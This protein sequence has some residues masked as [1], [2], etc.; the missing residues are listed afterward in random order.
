[1]VSV[2]DS[3]IKFC[4]LNLMP[5]VR[6]VHPWSPI[7]SLQLPLWLSRSVITPGFSL[8]I[9][10]ISVLLIEAGTYCLAP[11]LTRRSAIRQNSIS[12]CA[13]M[14]AFR[15][16]AGLLIIMFCGTRTNLLLMSCKLSQTTC[17]THMLDAPAPYQLFLPHIMHIWQPSGLGSTWSRTPL[18]AGPWLAVHVVVLHRAVHAAAP[19]SGMLLSG[20]SL[21]SRKTSSASCFTAR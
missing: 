3:S 18:T 19:G 2:R 17:A 8:T 4:C 15:E 7:I 5:F 14:L 11:L 20:L 9:T 13:A 6:P 1:M 21:P 12:T 16:Q 10:M